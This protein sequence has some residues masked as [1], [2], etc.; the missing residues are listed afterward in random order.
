M[1][2]RQIAELENLVPTWKYYHCEGSL[3]RVRYALDLRYS[4]VCGFDAGGNGTT[5]LNMKSMQHV[6]S[7]SSHKLK[8]DLYMIRIYSTMRK[9]LNIFLLRYIGLYI[10]IFF[11]YTEM[12]ITIYLLTIGLKVYSFLTS[13]RTK[14]QNEPFILCTVYEKNK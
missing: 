5:Y 10:Y 13:E 7:D 6:Q 3:Y 9:L 11:F 1:Q 8:P 12:K 2:T 14:Y 4:F